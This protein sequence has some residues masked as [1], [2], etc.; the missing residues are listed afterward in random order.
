PRRIEDGDLQRVHVGARRLGVEKQRVH[1]AQASHDLPPYHPRDRGSRGS[2]SSCTPS[3][4]ST[5]A[6]E[7]VWVIPMQEELVDVAGVHRTYIGMSERGERQ[8][9]IATSL[10]IRQSVAT[11]ETSTQAFL[12]AIGLNPPSGKLAPRQ[13]ARCLNDPLQRRA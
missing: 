2:R 5:R 10:G 11:I 12:I 8:P 13:L 3:P 6:T 7:N 9:T 1:R 4:T